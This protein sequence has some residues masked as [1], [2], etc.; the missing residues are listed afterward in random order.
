MTNEI[1]HFSK[2]QNFFNISPKE[3][4]WEMEDRARWDI[5]RMGSS[6]EGVA[7]KTGSSER[8]LGKKGRL[9]QEGWTLNT[10]EVTR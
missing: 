10:T 4:N 7:Q 3:S 9:Q 6:G 8:R 5:L 2:A 1:F